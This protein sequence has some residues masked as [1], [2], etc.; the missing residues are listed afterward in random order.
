M[1]FREKISLENKD[2]DSS[3]IC[4]KLHSANNSHRTPRGGNFYF[5]GEHVKYIRRSH[6]PMY[7]QQISLSC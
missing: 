1:S 2:Q 4:P 6:T 5:V 3:R 7:L